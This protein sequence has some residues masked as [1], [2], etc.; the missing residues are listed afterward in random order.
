MKKLFFIAIFCGILLPYFA[1]AAWWN[2]MTWFE[3]K[4]EAA[5]VKNE[6]MLITPKTIQ[7]S[8]SSPVN[9]KVVEKII[10]KPVIKEKLVTQTITV[11]NPELQIKIN[12]LIT[13]NSNLQSQI[14]TLKNQLN[15]CKTNLYE[16]TSS[17]SAT[18]SESEQC[19]TAKSDYKIATDKE[20][21]IEQWY[22]TEYAKIIGSGTDVQRSAQKLALDNQRSLKIDPVILDKNRA[23]RDIRMYCN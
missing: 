1:L 8:T 15:S 12:S 13:E 16:K 9:E 20:F 22:N 23:N 17:M 2:P 3:Q 14:N 5:E 6:A 21:A 7:T 19:L 18:V 10:E 11:D 4:N